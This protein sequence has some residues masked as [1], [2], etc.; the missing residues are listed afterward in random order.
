M[1]RKLS[2]TNG[3]FGSCRICKIL[4]SNP[5]RLTFFAVVDAGPLDWSDHAIWWPTKNTWLLRSRR[6]L[7][8]Y[9][10]P[11]GAVLWFTPMHRRIRVNFPDLQLIDVRI[12]FSANVFNNVISICK[13]FGI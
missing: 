6:T 8:Q 1:C 5:C 7:D 4:V 9:D 3:S 13:N 12:N 10:V 2:G 11:A